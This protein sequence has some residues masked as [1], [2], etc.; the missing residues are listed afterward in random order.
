MGKYLAFIICL[1]PLFTIKAQADTASAAAD[2]YIVQNGVKV[3]IVNNTCIIKQK[4]FEIVIAITEN[5]ILFTDLSPDST[6]FNKMKAL[7]KA[8]LD[9]FKPR[10]IPEYYTGITKK[11]IIKRSVKYFV[12]YKVRY[13][14]REVVGASRGKKTSLRKLTQPLFLFMLYYK[15]KLPTTLTF[16]KFIKIEWVK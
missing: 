4:P 10:Y 13:N 7:P 9:T 12:T 14:I 15:Y 3:P 1:V 16:S 6:E 5:G 8:V 2:I 11:T